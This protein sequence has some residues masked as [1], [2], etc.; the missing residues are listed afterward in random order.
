MT[1]TTPPAADKPDGNGQPEPARPQLTPEMIRQLLPRP[2]DLLRFQ[3]RLTWAISGCFIVLIGAILAALYIP[4]W[5]YANRARELVRSNIALLRDGKVDEARAQWDPI[6]A[7]DFYAELKRLG[8]LDRLRVSGA[9]TVNDFSTRDGNASVT[10]WIHS[11]DNT[12]PAGF[13]V[14]VFLDRDG[15][16]RIYQFSWDQLKD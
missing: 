8:L 6:S 2:Q 12:P 15:E 5:D 3:R 4:Y 14:I 11:N 10:G 7:D 16:L 9:V 13:R 1:D